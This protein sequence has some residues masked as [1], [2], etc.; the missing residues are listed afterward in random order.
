MK[1]VSW[2]LGWL[3]RLRWPRHGRRL[4]DRQRGQLDARINLHTGA[5]DPAAV[6]IGGID[7][8]VPAFDAAHGDDLHRRARSYAA[9]HEIERTRTGVA[10]RRPGDQRWPWREGRR[11]G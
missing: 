9:D 2:C 8:H 10:Q 1:W 5:F 11:G 6:V 3:R 7:D 4:E